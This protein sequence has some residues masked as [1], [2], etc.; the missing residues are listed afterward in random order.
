MNFPRYKSKFTEPSL[1]MDMDAQDPEN[2]RTWSSRK[3]LLVASFK[4]T[5]H[6]STLRYH[7]KSDRRGVGRPGPDVDRD[8]ENAEDG[9]AG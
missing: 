8:R 1:P 3:K 5:T 7:L 6:T 4:F 2:P 9:S